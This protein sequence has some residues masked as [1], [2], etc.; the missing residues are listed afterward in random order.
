[1][2]GGRDRGLLSIGIFLM[3]IV[4][5]IIL[6]TPLGLV[7]WSLIPPLVLA[8]FGCWT[9]FL[10]GIRMSNPLK[11]ERDPFSTFA[12]GLILLVIGG[13]WF[14]LSVSWLYS[15]AIILLVLG[16]LAIAAALRRK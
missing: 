6:Y 12:G 5:S 8:L 15:L 1:M 13:A 7:P 10:A 16:V 9:I 14:F 4:V 3:I 11:Y 2:A